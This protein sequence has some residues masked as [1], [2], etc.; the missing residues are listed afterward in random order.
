[1][2]SYGLQYRMLEGERGVKA[3]EE[4]KE[5]GGENEKDGGAPGGGDD[6]DD[7]DSQGG[8]DNNDDSG[9]GAGAGAGA[10][11]S[12]SSSSP[13]AGSKRKG[14]AAASSATSGSPG[15]S[16]SKS[17]KRRRRAA[18]S[19]DD[20]MDGQSDGGD[21]DDNNSGAAGGGDGLEFDE[22][23]EDAGFVR[24]A[25]GRKG[26][27]G[28]KKGS[29]SSSS[30]GIVGRKDGKAAAPLVEPVSD[31][32]GAGAGEDQWA[33]M[34]EEDER[35]VVE[36]DLYPN[37]AGDADIPS[38]PSD[39]AQR[40]KSEMAVVKKAVSSALRSAESTTI[41][42]LQRSLGE[43]ASGVQLS[44]KLLAAILEALNGEVTSFMFDAPSQMILKL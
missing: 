19:D 25:K 26:K 13:S 18:E 17:S 8:D 32:E 36:V 11:S 3:K 38:D 34:M 5:K 30:V 31:D 21:D 40:Y 41:T 39:I 20:E 2:Y 28:G 37:P 33:A 12:S 35:M 43:A 16:G 44:R 6:D 10:G 9:A 23:D 1:M 24:K 27:F 22:D 7:G 29:S 14:K 4:K 15:G 42:A